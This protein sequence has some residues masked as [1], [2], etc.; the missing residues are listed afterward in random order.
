MKT[1][2]EYPLIGLALLLAGI[3]AWNAW[4]GTQVDL[5]VAALSATTAGKDLPAE[6]TLAGEWIVKGLINAV[7][8]GSVTALVGAGI[9]WARRQWKKAQRPEWKSGPNANWG[10]APQ[11]KA[12]R[13]MS[14]AEF[15]RLLLAQQMA[16]T[17]GKA[18]VMLPRLEEDDEPNFT[19]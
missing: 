8:G 1:G 12:P 16:G 5:A 4:Q 18:Q 9:W 19:L 10:Q 17:G 6:A 13:A 14:E 7:I 15:Y 11:A 2:M 3:L